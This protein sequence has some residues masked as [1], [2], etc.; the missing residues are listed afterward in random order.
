MY[1]AYLMQCMPP[2]CTVNIFNRLCISGRWLLGVDCAA[3]ATQ[4]GDVKEAAPRRRTLVEDGDLGFIS[5]FLILATM[6]DW[7][8]DWERRMER[9]CALISTTVVQA[10]PEEGHSIGS[11]KRH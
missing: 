4:R 7:E 10:R 8:L 1:Y 9:L 2:S 6:L 11:E 5:I 3:E